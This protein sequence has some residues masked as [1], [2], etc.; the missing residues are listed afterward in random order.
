MKVMGRMMRGAVL[1]ALLCILGWSTASLAQEA[2]RAPEAESGR[3]EKQ[4]AIA[5]R[6]MV[7]AAHPLAAQAGREMLRRGGS[8]VDAAIAV[9]LV[10]GLVEPQSS[11]LGGGAF[12]VH[13][14]AGAKALTTFDGRETAPAAATPNRF[15]MSD[16]VAMDFDQAVRS[17]LSV[18]VPGVLRA[19]EAAHT[20]FGKLAW[21]ELFQPAIR[22]AREGFPMSPR[23]NALLTIEGPSR[24]ALEA[25]K[26]Y[27]DAAGTPL[28][29]GTPVRNEAYAVTLE[30]IATQGA[31]AFYEGD[32]AQAIVSAVAAAPYA[33]GDLTLED[34]KSYRAIERE[35]LCFPYRDRKICG[36]GPPSSGTLTVGQTL[37]LV[38]PLA[39][40]D[41][42][43]ARASAQ[44]L[45]LIAEAEK[46]AFAD[47]NRYVAD[48]AFAPVPAGMLDP[49]YLAQRRELLS[50]ARAMEKPTA[51]VPPGVAKR[52]SAE[53]TTREIA[54][55]S[56]L[57]IID[58]AGNAVSMTTTIESAF[59]SHLMAAG[60]LLNNEMTDFALLPVGKDGV[61]VAN[62][63]EAGKRP[64]SSMTPLLGFNAAGDLEFVT[65]SP[66]GSRIIFYM[67]KALV[68][69]ID[70]GASPQDAAA[71][72][73]FGSDGG[74]FVL[75]SGAV[76]F[77][78]VQALK[79]YGHA[80]THEAMTSGVHTIRRVPGG[81]EGGADPRREGV[82]LGD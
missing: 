75:E 22:L 38:E 43:G 9:Q 23:L 46:L 49:A 12:L 73:N 55:T 82:A 76:D 37:S 80:V 79:S 42:V 39:G 2:W 4:G 65:G 6:H 68:A 57:S 45:H 67:V 62:R 11:G 35:A 28:T 51:G 71:L 60:F 15:V 1:P 27:F 40:I 48:P 61:A 24:F 26:V 66:G 41:G 59:G 18:G 20:K 58:G 50:R 36:M 53:D 13:F 16:G 5:T 29:V 32:I 78:L 30:A 70:W 63:V 21:A 74:A 64:R 14:D 33:K 44:A 77:W 10:L 3:T 25:R 17:G 54:G 7:V 69:M 34:L 52:T 19:L 56:H 31:Q 47:R 81:L 72:M 8:A